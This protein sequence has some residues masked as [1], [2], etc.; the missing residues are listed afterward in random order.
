MAVLFA[1][2]ARTTPGASSIVDVGTGTFR[3]ALAVTITVL[4]IA[5]DDESYTYALQGSP[6][7]DFG[8][9][10]S[11]QELASIVVCAKEV[12]ATDSDKDG[13][14]G[15][16]VL[17]V[18]N[19]FG[20][21]TYRYLRLYYVPSGTT[22]SSTFSADLRIERV[23]AVNQ[24]GTGAVESDGRIKCW[25]TVGDAPRRLFPVDFKAALAGAV[26]TLTHP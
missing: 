26:V 24:D 6:D 20:A 2:G 18:N 9:A 15:T 4:D 25:D 16:Y 5:D 22:T 21:T 13:A 7:F 8:T 10:G 3:G 1:S 17:P 14:T 12:R 11:I 19:I 23:A